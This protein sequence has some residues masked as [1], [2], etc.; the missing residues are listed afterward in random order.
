M[1]AA[2]NHQDPV[3]ALHNQV[4]RLRRTIPFTRIETVAPGYRLAVDPDDVDSQRFDRLVRADTAGSLSEALSLW[5]GA[6]YAC[7]RQADALAAYQRYA[8]RL[9]DELGL[10]P[11]A[12]MQELRLRVLRHNIAPPT[13]LRAMRVSHVTVGDRRIAVATVGSGQ[14]L[15]ALPGWVSNIDV[16]AAGRD[17]RSSMFQRLVGTRALVMYDRYGTGRSPGPVD[18]FGLDASVA[19][20]AAVATHAGAPVDLLAMSQAGPVAVAL[21]ATRPDL[22]RRPTLPAPSP[23][24]CPADRASGYAGMRAQPPV[25]ADHPVQ[26]LV[27]HSGSSESRPAPSSFVTSDRTIQFPGLTEVSAARH[28]SSVRVSNAR[29]RRTSDGTVDGMDL[30]E[31]DGR[32]Q[33]HRDRRVNLNG[34]CGVCASRGLSN[35]TGTAVRLRRRSPSPICRRPGFWPTIRRQS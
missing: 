34:S 15:I 35:S 26:P 13:P 8:G 5:H 7:G 32:D 30:S 1:P 14:P 33:I 12:A 9:A 4:S 10:E 6:A 21:A 16:I 28:S 29:Q 27:L 2:G 19:E 3:A 23:R 17:P 31:R 24:S 20:L 25:S 18:D 11:S 22:V